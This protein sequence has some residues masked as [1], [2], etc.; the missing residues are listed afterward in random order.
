MPNIYLLQKHTS[1][2]KGEGKRECLWAVERETLRG[3]PCTHTCELVRAC[4]FISLAQ[5]GGRVALAAKWFSMLMSCYLWCCRNNILSF[6]QWESSLLG[7]DYTVHTAKVVIYIFIQS[8]K[9]IHK[10]TYTSTD[11]PIN[12]QA[13]LH[14]N[15]GSCTLTHHHQH[16]HKLRGNLRWIFVLHQ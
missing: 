16:Q 6:S 15:T 2:Q 13:E 12:K 7:T 1:S 8:S 5:M 4:V 3:G 14:F 10:C 9:K 11:R